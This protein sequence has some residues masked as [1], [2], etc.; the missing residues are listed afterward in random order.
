META[1][2]LVG[3]GATVTLVSE[4]LYNKL[5]MSLRPNLHVVTQTI[6]TANSTAFS[7]RGKAE[8]NVCIDKMT[9]YY[10]GP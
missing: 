1:R 4:S 7:V 8:F 6:M 10:L 2:F 5:P 9:Y 3:T